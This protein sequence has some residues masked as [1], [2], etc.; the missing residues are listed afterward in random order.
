[1]NEL[2]PPQILDILPALHTLLSKLLESEDS[3]AFL[4]NKD[5]AAM[6]TSLKQRVQRARASLEQTPSM[7]R[8]LDGEEEIAMLQKKI[9]RQEQALVKIAKAIGSDTST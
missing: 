9:S 3:D 4:L 7:D 1:M 5:I 8:P 2:P 6:V